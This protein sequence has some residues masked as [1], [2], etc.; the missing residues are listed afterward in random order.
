[1]DDKSE[2]IVRSLKEDQII[3]EG[4]ITLHRLNAIFQ[5]EIPEEED[6]LSG[7][8]YFLFDDIPDKGDSIE[9]DGLKFDVLQMEENTIR[10]VKVTK[11]K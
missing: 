7:Y 1:M 5:T 11:L 2:A 9:I 4:K 3:C 10:L 8:L 6:T